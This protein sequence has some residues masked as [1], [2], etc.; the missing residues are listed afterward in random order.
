MREAR[1]LDAVDGAAGL[2]RP[3]GDDRAALQRVPPALRRDAATRWPRSWSRRARTA[4]ASRGRTGTTS[5][6][7]AEDYLAARVIADP[8]CM[9]DCDIPVDGVA[10]FVFTSAERARDLPQPPGVRR[11]ATRR[12]RRPT[13]ASRCTGR[14]TTSWT[15]ASRPP[16]GCGSTSGVGPADV[17]LPQVYDGFSPFVWF[18]LEVARL[19][20]G[21][22]GARVRAGR[23]HR[24][25]RA[26]RRCRRCRAAARSA[27]AAC[28]ASR[29]CSS[30]TC[31]S[32]GRAGDRQRDERDGRRGLPLVAAL[33]RRRRLQ[34]T[35]LLTARE[36][37]GWCRENSC[38]LPRSMF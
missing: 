24:Q 16:A 12:A 15:P 1:G 23:R 8:I 9:Y 37:S 30:A 11:A 6:L 32:S 2:L 25:R 38:E 34:R 27:T 20:P 31:S 21:R 19:L 10:A 7:T 3:A 18:W 35:P 14:S 28:T 22:R 5:P 4:R 13:D 26:R 29:R 33:R 17:D 36:Q